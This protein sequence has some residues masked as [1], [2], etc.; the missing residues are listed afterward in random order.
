LLWVVSWVCLCILRWAAGGQLG[1]R[2][3]SLLH[4][5]LSEYLL[6]VRAVTKG[7]GAA[8]E[9]RI[10]AQ[11][12]LRLPMNAK[13]GVDEKRAEGPAWQCSASYVML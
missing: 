10:L 3:G 13:S 6:A 11:P 9:G 7:I 12:D 5:T 8:G 1:C 2:N 4:G